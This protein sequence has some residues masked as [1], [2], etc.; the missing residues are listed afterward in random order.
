MNYDWE[1]Q[2]G[3]YYNYFTSGVACSEVEVDMLT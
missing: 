2:T 1:A 3:R